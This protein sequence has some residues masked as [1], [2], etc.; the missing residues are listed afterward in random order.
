MRTEPLL[1][2][3]P[4]SLEY[5]KANKNRKIMYK[6]RPCRG[7]KQWSITVV[8]PGSMAR[9]ETI[10]AVRWASLWSTHPT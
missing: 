2:T 10:E 9:S 1:H 6:I 7:S 5:L 4:I 8:A 3:F